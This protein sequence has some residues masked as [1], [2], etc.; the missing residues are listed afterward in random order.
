M[1]IRN[2]ILLFGCLSV[3]AS[4][5]STPNAPSNPNPAAVT[6]TMVAPDTVSIMDTVHL[7]VACSAI[8]KSTWCYRWDFANSDSLITKDSTC[9]HVFLNPGAVSVRVSLID[10]LHDSL[11]ATSS[12][13]IAVLPRTFDL[14]V[15]QGYDSVSITAFGIV[16][17]HTG[18]QSFGSP[19]GEKFDSG[20]GFG[21]ATY[22]FPIV[23]NG[24]AFRF[25]DSASDHININD[26]VSGHREVSSSHRLD[27]VLGHVN[28]AHTMLIDINAIHDNGSSYQLNGIN[29]SYGGSSSYTNAGFTQVQFV[30]QT[31]ST[32]TFESTRLSPSASRFSQGSDD[33]NGVRSSRNDK[34]NSTTFDWNDNNAVSRVKIVFKR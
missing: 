7:R 17:W 3:L 6:L 28:V 32:M 11:I 30:G 33:Y 25:L 19:S 21:S 12:T 23:W 5:A 2:R 10:S 1:K 26:T 22:T 29:G 14:T 34:Y 16:S 18:Y 8:R 31:S 24:L 9:S 20:R 13:S 15:L 27:S 4:C